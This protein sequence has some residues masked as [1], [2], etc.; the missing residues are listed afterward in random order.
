MNQNN[1]S[2]T[3]E[4]KY[5]QLSVFEKYCFL[6]IM[7]YPTLM[8]TKKDVLKYIFIN[9]KID[10]SKNSIYKYMRNYHSIDTLS[11]DS[12]YKLMYY[13]EKRNNKEL[14]SNLY[15]Q[16]KMN[17]DMNKYIKK[18]ENNKNFSLEEKILN[19]LKKVS[20]VENNYENIIF[21]NIFELIKLDLNNDLY[22]LY[23]E[24]KIS[25]SDY[26]ILMKSENQQ[27]E[28]DKQMFS[29]EQL[30]KEKNDRL[31]SYHNSILKEDSNL[32]NHA[33]DIDESFLKAREEYFNYLNN[34]DDKIKCYIDIKEK[35]ISMNKKYINKI[36]NSQGKIVNKIIIRFHDNDFYDILNKT[37]ELLL[38]NKLF[39]FSNF[40]KDLVNNEKD[41]N[42]IIK[43]RKEL[44]YNEFNKLFPLMYEL[45][46]LTNNNDNKFNYI[47]YL[48]ISS[49][50]NILFDTFDN[51]KKQFEEINKYGDNSESIVIDL[52]EQI[53][54]NI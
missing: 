26:E 34:F 11:G 25:K 20:N 46:N 31:K 41:Y 5:N 39:Q 27:I 49:V 19:K 47:E 28:F 33:I 8:K 32:F 38:N 42:E 23:E 7:E 17:F 18:N 22:S 37:G 16:I 24:S 35:L 40:S 9:H 2:L 13:F 12:F 45:N 54:Y 6:Q 3:N 15:D 52:K 10:L 30:E 50:D 48:K 53:V 36:I 1:S 51:D 44:I 21:K 14:L 43:Q 4:E 29:K